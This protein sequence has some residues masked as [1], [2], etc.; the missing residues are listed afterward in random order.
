VVAA[1]PNAGGQGRV[2]VI[3]EKGAGPCADLPFA[4]TGIGLGSPEDVFVADGK[5]GTVVPFKVEADKL[6]AGDAITVGEEPHG[7]LLA[8]KGRLYVPLAGSIG[9][10]D[11]ATL[12]TAAAISLPG[13][14]ENIWIVPFNGRLFATLPA[15]DQVALADAIAPEGEPVTLVSVKRPAAVAGPATSSPSG[16]VVYV[17]SVGDGALARLDAL[18]GELLS[19]VAVAALAP[20]TEVEPAEATAASFE[21]SEDGATATIVFEGGKLNKAGILVRDGDLSDGKATLEVWQGA[22]DS[23]IEKEEGEGVT[24]RVDR[25]PARLKI[26]VTAPPGTFAEISARLTPDGKAVVLTAEAAK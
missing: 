2:C 4:P 22:I 17:A 7:T 8:F 5:A 12:A 10:L 24:V 3:S 20:K 1:A 25:A 14:P 19:Q 26:V 9:I 15:S 23:S 13:R 16:D 21:A 18:S 6:T 11:L